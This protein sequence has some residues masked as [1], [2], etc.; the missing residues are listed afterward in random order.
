MQHKN[1]LDL[2]RN[3]PHRHLAA[4]LMVTMSEDLKSV[5]IFT[6]TPM[7]GMGPGTGDFQKPGAQWFD[8]LTK[9]IEAGNAGAAGSR[10]PW[11]AQGEVIFNADHI[12]VLCSLFRKKKLEAAT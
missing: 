6:P 10:F 8:D 3:Q 2:D 11:V 7:P 9:A 4:A 12:R 1:G 5:L